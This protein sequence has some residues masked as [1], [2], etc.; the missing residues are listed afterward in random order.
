MYFYSATSEM[1]LHI[2]GALWTFLVNKVIPRMHCSSLLIYNVFK[3]FE[4]CI[5]NIH[6]YRILQSLCF[7]WILP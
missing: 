4:T 6:L 3:K 7:C 2:I 5:V 1:L